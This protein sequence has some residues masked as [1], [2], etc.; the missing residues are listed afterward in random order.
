VP[1]RLRRLGPA[2]PWALGLGYAA[3]LVVVDTLTR[4]LP[5][6][7]GAAARA[8]LSTNLDTLSS[9]LHGVAALLGSA[10][11]AEE[12]VGW[13]A[14]FAVAGL[15]VAGRR[16]GAVRAGA[17]ALAAHVLATLASEGL[18]ALRIAA[19]DA[20]A[21]DRGLLDVGPSYLVVGAL[22]AGIAYGRRWER[23]APAVAFALVAPYLFGGLTDLDVTPVGH[24]TSAVLALG[25][26][27]AAARRART[28]AVPAA[29]AAS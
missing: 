4:V 13:W 18:L 8:W 20:P 19:G 22:A 9:P 24:A 5:D 7:D 28:P 2:G 15:T 26:G 25:L 10:F 29:S 17:L 21:S 27:A 11:V 23:V 6:D 12:S 16:F 3:A 1:A 14:V